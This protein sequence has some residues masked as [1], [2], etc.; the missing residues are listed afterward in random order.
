MLDSKSIVSSAYQVVGGNLQMTTSTSGAT[1]TVQTFSLVHNLVFMKAQYGV[2]PPASQ[3][4]DSWVNPTGT[5]DPSALAAN[6]AN[7]VR[8]KAVRI[9]VVARSDKREADAVTPQCTNVSLTVNNG[10]CAWRDTAASPAPVID[11]SADP[12][13]QH[14]RYKVYQTVVPLRNVI[15]DNV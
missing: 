11:L 2:A 7:R 13:W 6:P 5:W 9:V 10:P 8:I 15:W 12:D 14:Y 3:S 4:V 1:P